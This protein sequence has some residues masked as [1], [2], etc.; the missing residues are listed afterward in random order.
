MNS[1]P[2]MIRNGMVLEH[3]LDKWNPVIENLLSHLGI[4]ELN[5]FD[6]PV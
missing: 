1:N 3:G 4:T 2:V 6:S 5:P